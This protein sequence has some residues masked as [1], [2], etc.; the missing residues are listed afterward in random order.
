M[1][2]IKYN[3]GANDTSLYHSCYHCNYS[4]VQVAFQNKK[5][6]L[7]TTCGKGLKCKWGGCK[8][9]EPIHKW[10]LR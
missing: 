9:W 5:T 7:I 8:E 1:D 4:V 2:R 6:Y 10:W 3:Y